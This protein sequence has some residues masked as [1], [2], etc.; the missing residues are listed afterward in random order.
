MHLG[1]AANKAISFGVGIF[2]TLL[3]ASGV[4]TM[5]SQMQNIYKEVNETDTSVTSRFG[6]YAMYD[7]TTITGLEVI[8]CANKYYNDNLIVVEYSGV[9]L[10]TEIGLEYLDDQLNLETIKYEDKFKSMVEEVEY[11]GVTK[12]KISFTKM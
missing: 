3:I 11:D 9:E 10:N 2:V 8:N 7:N 1:E 5:F 6:R 12:T 4:I